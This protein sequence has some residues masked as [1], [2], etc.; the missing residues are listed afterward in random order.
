MA[1]LHEISWIKKDC[2]VARSRKAGFCEYMKQGKFQRNFLMMTFRSDSRYMVLVRNIGQQQLNLCRQT[3]KF[4]NS[5]WSLGPNLWAP[6]LRGAEGL[7][8][9]GVF[10][11]EKQATVESGELGGLVG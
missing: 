10:G 1:F 9:H 3:P 4:A 7:A 5:A 8:T 2:L 11:G 6:Q